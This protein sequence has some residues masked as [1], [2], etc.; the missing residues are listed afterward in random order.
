MP[1]PTL[2]L[3][4]GE[5]APDAPPLRSPGSPPPGGKKD[6]VELLLE[7]ME[8][9]KPD[10]T[11]TT[12]QSHG[13]AAAAYHAEHVLR[14]AGVLRDDGPKVLVERGSL[15]AA[16]GGAMVTTEPV[17]RHPRTL[18]RRI[19]AATV[20]GLLVVLALFGVMRATAGTSPPSSSAAAAVP[21]QAPSPTLAPLAPAVPAAAPAAAEVS[22]VAVAAAEGEAIPTARST[23][24]AR[25]TPAVAPAPSRRPAART[26]PTAPPGPA[27]TGGS[28]GEFKTHF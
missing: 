1:P 27:G 19:V 8:E 9:P 7:G 22:A 11:K 23:D 4:L 20:A 25:T 18:A 12:P 28:L 21:W 3:P 15:L 17:G 26:S 2:R 14:P 13:E 16:S 5:L 10:R 6:S 24:G